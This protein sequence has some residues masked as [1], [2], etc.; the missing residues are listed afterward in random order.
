MAL[1]TKSIFFVKFTI[2]NFSFHELTW[3]LWDFIFWRTHFC[4]NG[5]INSHFGLRLNTDIFLKIKTTK[6]IILQTHTLICSYI[7][8]FTCSTNIIINWIIKILITIFKFFFECCYCSC[9]T[10]I[11]SFKWIFNWDTRLPITTQN[12]I[13]STL[14]TNINY[15]GHYTIGNQNTILN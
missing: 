12:I 7:G 13:R 8:R 5:L 10:T 4:Q 14:L 2:S 11:S 9:I 1:N 6:N 3:N 15:S